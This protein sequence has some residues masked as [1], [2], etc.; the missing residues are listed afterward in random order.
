M[1]SGFRRILIVK[2]SS[3]GDI[4]HAI[5]SYA[6]LRRNLPNAEICWLVE[7]RFAELLSLVRKLD[8]VISVDTFQ[9]RRNIFSEQT[10]GDVLNTY[11]MLKKIEYD[12]VIDYQGLVKSGMFTYLSRS[13]VRVGFDTDN[14]RE[15]L[16]GM[17]YTDV[18][19]V[20]KKI[21][22]VIL[23]NLHLTEKFLQGAGFKSGDLEN[24][25]LVTRYLSPADL[26][27]LDPG[28]KADLSA[29]LR[30]RGVESFILLHTGSSSLNKLL[31]VS[32]HAALCD[33]LYDEHNF[34]IVL[35]G[36][37][38]DIYTAER[39]YAE[40]TS[41]RPIIKETQTDELAGLIDLS[42]VFVGSDSGP[43]HL[44]SL[45]GA[46]VVGLYGP[47]NP[48]RNGPI[49]KNS[50]VIESKM[51]CRRRSCWKSCEDNICM[52]S[53]HAEEV[54]EKVISLVRD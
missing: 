15:P 6:M 11:K 26:L 29:E 9:W 27:Q 8:K 10:M 34:D 23:Q 14:I 45:L 42:K 24:N 20:D 30:D 47:T 40:C 7:R 35:C 17:F 19:R 4:V 49:T 5:P 18:Y 52:K 28:L 25:D 38:E 51:S 21:E 22:N 36:R 48:N 46:N 1:N 31:P 3:F 44:A 16:A 43:L 2:L 53:I 13:P 12:A 50:V 54:V 37:G 41:A 33:I 32:T 39:I